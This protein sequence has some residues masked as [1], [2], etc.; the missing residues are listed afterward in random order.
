[1]S[2]R[3]K[4]T[5]EYDGTGFNGWQKQPHGRTVQGVIEQ[6]LSTFYQRKINV[7]GQGRTDAGVH[8]KAQI[9]HADLPSTYS[10][11]RLHRAMHGLLPKDVALVEAEVVSDNFHARF[12]AISRSYR[13]IVVNK[14]SPILRHYSWHVFKPID[15]SLLHQCAELI[16]GKHDFVN[17]CI[18]QD[19]VNLTT[20]CRINKSYWQTTDC[21]YEY[22]IQ[23]NRFLRHL[24]RRLTGAMVRVAD[25]TNQ[26]EY[27][28][29][30]LSGMEKTQKAFAAP[31]KGLTLI[32]VEY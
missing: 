8:A 26:I 4:L 23:G 24:V 9:A 14:P 13:Y 19:Q 27:F 32:E 16:L 22:R 7:S 17:F 10:I 31:A 15:I 5:F 21:G 3:Y 1:M 28:K 29:E 6:A 2:K 12:H 30:L 25:G 11:E 18:P 20:I